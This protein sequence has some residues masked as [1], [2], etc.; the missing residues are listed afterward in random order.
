MGALQLRS[1]T[2][3]G[4]QEDHRGAA[5]LF[6]S[7]LCTGTVPSIER[8]PSLWHCLDELHNRSNCSLRHSDSYVPVPAGQKYVRHASRDS[9]KWAKLAGRRRLHDCRSVLLVQMEKMLASKADLGA[10]GIVVGEF[11]PGVGIESAVH[12]VEQ[13]TVVLLV[14]CWTRSSSCSMI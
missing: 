12:G 9:W 14:G 7:L 5:T 13:N 8:T 3:E 2:G 6:Q 11:L 10:V 4:M 1:Q